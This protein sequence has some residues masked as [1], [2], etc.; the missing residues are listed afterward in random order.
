[1]I[2]IKNLTLGYDKHPVVHHLNAEINIGDSIAIVGPNGGGKSTL[3]KGLM[4]LIKPMDGEINHAF[5][6]NQ[7][8]YLPQISSIDKTFPISAYELIASGLWHKTG[9]FKRYTNEDKSLIEKAIIQVGLCGMQNEPLEA[10]SGGQI[11]RA[12]FARLILQNANFILLDEPFNAIDY[13]TTIELLSII[14]HWKKQNKTI[15]AVLHNYQHVKEN[16]EKTLI[17][18]REIIDYGDT[19]EVLNENNI[20]KAFNIRTYPHEHA[21]ICSR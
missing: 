17:I 5:S 15:L 4:G 9:W 21:S 2:T 20:N 18:A 11:Q 14:K 7:I 3:L 12:L 19:Q 8:A 13:K 6:R 10:L 1:M 16:F